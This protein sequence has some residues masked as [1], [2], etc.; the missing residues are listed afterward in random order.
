MEWLDENFPPYI[1]AGDET[2]ESLSH[3]RV[4]PNPF[5]EAVVV[6]ATLR[7]PSTVTVQIINTMG[8]IVHQSIDWED[9]TRYEK[10]LNLLTLAKGAYVCVIYVNGTSVWSGRM[11]K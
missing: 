4:Y 7:Q 3:V 1:I 5:H 10:H 2:L 11:V 9:T 8:Q 6:K